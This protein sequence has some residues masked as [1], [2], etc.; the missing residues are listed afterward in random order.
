M[1]LG[2]AHIKGAGGVRLGKLVNAGAAGHGGGD[3]DNA[4]V[5]LGQLGQRLAEHILIAGRPGR[6]LHLL[7]RHHIELGDAV[8]FVGGGFGRGIALALLRDDMD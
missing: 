7:A 2:N 5:R 8:I 6:G 3:G 4:L 1:L